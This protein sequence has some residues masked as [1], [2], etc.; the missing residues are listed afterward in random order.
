MRLHTTMLIPVMLVFF[1]ACGGG[2][3]EQVAGIDRGGVPS[4]GVV[5]KGTLTGFGSVIVNGVRYDTAS[6]TFRVDDNPG[7]ESDLKIGQVI[8]VEGTLDDDGTTGDADSVS[9]DDNVEGPVQ[10]L[11]VAGNTMVV[12]GQT[13]IVD[14]NTV[15]DDNI[16]PASLDGLMI[17]D[18]VEVSGLVRAD[19]SIGATRIEAKPAGGEFEVVGIV[20]NLNAGNMTFQI[21]DLVVDYSAAQLDDFPSGAPE[22]GDLVEAKGSTLVG[23]ELSATR[24][25]FKGDD[26]PGEDG[27]DVELE[28]FIGRFVDSS[29]FDVEG[30][31]V[32]TNGQ[33]TY[34]GGTVNDLALNVKVEVEGQLN[35]EVIEADK[36][37]FK[38]SSNIRVEALVQDVQANQST[39]T[40]LGITVNVTDTTQL[41]DKSNLDVEPLS[42]ADINVDD[43]VAVRGF[44]ENGEL[45][46]TR[47]ERDED[48]G[49]V[50]VR[51]VAENVAQPELNL[52]GVTVRTGAGTQ[53]EDLDDSPLTADQFFGQAEGR[54]VDAKGTLN[55]AVLEAEEVSLED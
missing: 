13:V 35:G 51:A 30:R 53:F 15:F 8:T 10:S 20:S 41:E 6:T 37:E 36:I 39:L 27:D 34:E 32:T 47:V 18:I 5:A 22:T 12:L 4:A 3:G 48:T 11:N 28:G 26:I 17:G 50:S 2:G 7:V 29:D 14:G 52:F 43:F 55:G 44:V 16:N 9:F 49:E 25:E 33:T 46:A 45:T 40:V 42:L 21:N 31:P 38:Q 19:G 54:L 1:S 24:V 23:S